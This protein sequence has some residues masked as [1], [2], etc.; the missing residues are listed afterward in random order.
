[1]AF[2]S[3]FFSFGYKRLDKDVKL[4]ILINLM[5]FNDFKLVQI[6]QKC[7]NLSNLGKLWWNLW[8]IGKLFICI[9]N[10]IILNDFE[11]V[12]PFP[13]LSKLVQNCP[14]LVKLG[15][16]L[17]KF[18]LNCQNLSELVKTCQTLSKFIKTCQNLSNIV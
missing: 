12:Q 6:V 4:I 17:S 10:L 18:V 13:N 2:V 14:N 7:L 11:F 8:K 9:D 3:P 16:N 15:Q 5:I 1:M